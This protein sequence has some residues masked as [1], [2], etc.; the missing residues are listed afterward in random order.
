MIS[1]PCKSAESAILTTSLSLAAVG[2]GLC[3][4]AETADPDLKKAAVRNGRSKRM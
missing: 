3:E 1:D 4:K 2:V